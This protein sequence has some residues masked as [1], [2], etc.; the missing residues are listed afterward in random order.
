M[1]NNS[2]VIHICNDAGFDLVGFALA[3]PLE[4]EVENL[5]NWLSKGYHSNMDYMERNLEKKRDVSEILNGA[6][7]V[8]SLG[9]NYY[10]DEAYENKSG[11]GKVSRYA[12]GKD[13]HF[14]IWDKLNNIIELLQSI[15]PTFEAISYVD[16]G[17]VMDKAWAVKA[18]I[19]WLGKHTNVINPEKGS[20]FFIAN[21]ICNKEFDYSEQIPDHCGTCTA[22]I[23]SCPTDAIISEYV[24]DSN[25]CISNLTIENK[26]EIPSEFLGKFENWIFGCDT[27][28]DVCPWNNK[29]SYQ[30]NEPDFTNI[31][32]KELSIEEIRGMSNSEFKKKFGMTPINRPR[33]KGLKRNAR[34]IEANLS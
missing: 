24:V 16:T 30:S 12:W 21:I 19:G 27:C 28:Q 3:E 8:I 5:K 10:V 9:L 6:K 15:D 4:N 25:K 17:P 33:L 29:F 1:I 11:Y 22:C 34:F 23:D 13:Y 31:L 2:T 32:N 7:S 26:K 20:W 18:G 14:V